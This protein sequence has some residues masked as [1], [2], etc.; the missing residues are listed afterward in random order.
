M[1]ANWQ[2]AFAISLNLRNSSEENPIYYPKSVGV[3]GLWH[4]KSLMSISMM[5]ELTFLVLELFCTQCNSYLL[6]LNSN[7]KRVNGA[8]PFKGREV[9]II[10]ENTLRAKV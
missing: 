10:L 5:R 4:L 6:I 9:N 1:K 7:K 2:H 8:L 3:Q